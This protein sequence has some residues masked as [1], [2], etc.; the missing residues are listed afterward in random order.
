VVT[1]FVGDDVV[2]V[3]KM[4][5]LGEVARLPHGVPIL[6]VAF[7]SDSSGMLTASSDGSLRTWAMPGEGVL[8]RELAADLQAVSLSAGGRFLATLDSAGT[9]DRSPV[10]KIWDFAEGAEVF[11]AE[12]PSG[13]HDQI[14]VGSTS[15]RAA[16]VSRDGKR[17]A[18]VGYWGAGHVAYVWDTPSQTPIFQADHSARVQSLALSPDGLYLATV[19]KGEGILWDLRQR[20]SSV[21]ESSPVR[22][23]EFSGDSRHIAII[24]ETR[25]AESCLKKDLPTGQHLHVLKL[26]P[27]TGGIA[28]TNQGSFIAVAAMQRIRIWDTVTCRV[29]GAFDEKEPIT[30]IAFDD[31]GGLL[32]ASTSQ[33]NAE[34]RNV[35]G[36]DRVYRI[37]HEGY[38]ANVGFSTVR[39]RHYLVTSNGY[40]TRQ[41]GEQAPNPE[42]T[43]RLWPWTAE[44]ILSGACHVLG[45]YDSRE[46]PQD[47]DFEASICRV[48]QAGY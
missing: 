48:C 14:S 10:L 47:P 29:V 40:L 32:A 30:A 15:T 19:S 33:G 28:I 31:T 16:A 38:L 12:L 46:F 27:G 9:S 37:H 26:A 17:A 24:E 42:N 45:S 43:A 8:E 34:I 23:V 25:G 1:A 39:N 18:A 7:L 5:T 22:R 35:P 6:K 20:R 13:A 44:D 4:D 36:G 41:Q 11:R 21:L 3:W 2:R